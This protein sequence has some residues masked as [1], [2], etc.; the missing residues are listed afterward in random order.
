MRI[1]VKE[2]KGKLRLADSHI[3]FSPFAPLV[4]GRENISLTVSCFH[5]AYLMQTTW[6]V[7]PGLQI[8]MS[9]SSLQSYLLS[10]LHHPVCVITFTLFF[11]FFNLLYQLHELKRHE[12]CRIQLSDLFIYSSCSLSNSSS[13]CVGTTRACI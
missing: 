10:F 11:F 8:R 1:R 3:F 12:V 13:T 4:Q 6:T 5:I 7:L 2:R 9:C